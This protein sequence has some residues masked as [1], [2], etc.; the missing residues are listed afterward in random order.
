M[1]FSGAQLRPHGCA[2]LHVRSRR[3]AARSTA[4]LRCAQRTARAR[5]AR[6][7][8]PAFLA[9]LRARASPRAL[10]PAL[11]HPTPLCVHL[12]PP[13]FASHTRAHSQRRPCAAASSDKPKKGG[14]ARIYVGKGKYVD[15]DPAK[16][17]GREDNAAAGGWAGGEKG[18]W[19]FRNELTSGK[20]AG[21]APM[22]EKPKTPSART[23]ASFDVDLSKDFN[24]MAGGFPGGE[25]G[26]KAFT[27][28][29]RAATAE[30]ESSSAP[31][32]SETARA[33]AR[34]AVCG[35]AVR[36]AR[37]APGR[38]R[39]APRQHARAALWRRN[40]APGAPTPPATRPSP[41]Y[42][43]PLSRTRRKPSSSASHATRRPRAQPGAPHRASW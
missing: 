32:G 20:E 22:A 1:A 41:T 42:L 39:G 25:V 34:W 9:L 26:L 35:R 29:V 2:A 30:E 21:K 10:T 31:G 7:I 23:A 8:G 14:S 19:A 6:R 33:R 27:E 4:P 37:L 36:C 43:P 16:Y 3:A 13:S 38:P 17:P 5:I 40:G 15:D 18:L 24:Q 12:R 28:T 11:A